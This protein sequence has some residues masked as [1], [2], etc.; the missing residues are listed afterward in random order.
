MGQRLLNREIDRC[1]VSYSQEDKQRNKNRRIKTWT[2]TEKG[3]QTDK[4]T[5]NGDID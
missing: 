1:M 3:K 4:T 2:N 5:E